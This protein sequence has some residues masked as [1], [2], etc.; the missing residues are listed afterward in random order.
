[1][2]RMM[3]VGPLKLVDL[4]ERRCVQTF[5]KTR[6]PWAG[7]GSW[8]RDGKETEVVVGPHQEEGTGVACKDHTLHQSQ[9]NRLWETP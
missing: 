6:I 9:K 5:D 3:W 2:A 4:D 7:E 8:A 1:M